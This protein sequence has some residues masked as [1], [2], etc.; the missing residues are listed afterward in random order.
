MF[1]HA[2]AGIDVCGGVGRI[3]TEPSLKVNLFFTMSWAMGFDFATDLPVFYEDRK[4]AKL[5]AWR[6]ICSTWTLL[7]GCSFS[8]W[9]NNP[10]NIEEW[11]SFVSYM[12]E[13]YSAQI[14]LT[15]YSSLG[16]MYIQGLSVVFPNQESMDR[17]FLTWV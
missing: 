1:S 8:G 7:K 3:M 13:H 12:D 9:K 15:V 5:F 14:V 11:Q 2:R 10:K 16:R 4:S 17:F 6:N